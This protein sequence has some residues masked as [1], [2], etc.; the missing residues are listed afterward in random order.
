M[1]KV[2]KFSD[3]ISTNDTLNKNSIQTGLDT[4]IRI[5]A[6]NCRYNGSK[7]QKSYKNK[8]VLPGRTQLLENVFPI[9]PNIAQHIFLND[10]LLGKFDANGNAL[11]PITVGNAPSVLLPR[12][13]EDLKLFKRRTVGYWC[14]GNGAVNQTISAQSYSPHINNVA[15][16]NMIPFRFVRSDSLLDPTK[17]AQYKF[18]VTFDNANSPYYGYT[19]YY[20]KKINFASLVG[21]NMTADKQEYTPKWGD[22]QA[23]L[24]DAMWEYESRFKGNVIQSNFIDMS[25]D[26]E[27][28]EFKEWFAFVDG[29]LS[30][31][32]ISEIGLV[33]GLDCFYDR[34]NSRL[35]VIEDLDPTASNY[36]T[37]A[38][39]S[40]IYDAELFA[41][42][43]F[44]PYPVSRENATIDFEYRIYS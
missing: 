31:A 23:N 41:H 9:T 42:L 44:D 37:K 4:E 11:N 15:L 35:E 24:V 38:A 1:K 21:I 13:Q 7:E 14:A 8:T 40:E 22:T 30:N 32:E 3:A 10:N 5:T 26:V 12:N 17:A 6:S 33:T 27:A 18:K 20:L 36:D 2:V 28:A 19:G 29:T 16:Y 34:T 43:T 39:A 25:M